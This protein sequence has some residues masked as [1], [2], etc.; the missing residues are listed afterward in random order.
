MRSFS[1]LEF[2]TRVQRA[3]AEM[4][5]ARLD[6]L[7]ITSE[8]NFRYF[9]GFDSQTWISPTRPRYFVL[10]R[11]GVPVAVV[12]ASHLSGMLAT[13]WVSEIRTWQAPDPSDDGMS[14]LASA[15]RE[16]RGSHGAIG[17]EI[18][19]ESRLG[20]PV[21]DFL[22]LQQ[23]L[24]P[25]VIRDGGAVFSVVRMIK[26]PSEIDRIRRAA[27]I[28]SD[29]FETL[30]G[31][32]REGMTERQACSAL[33][34]DLIRRGA[35][36]VPYLVG[37]AGSGG[38]DNTNMG[39]TDRVLARGDILYIDAG[40]TFGGYFCD[41]NR[42]FSFGPPPMEARRAFDAVYRATEA[43]IAAVHP[44]Q[45]AR[46][47]W[48]AMADSL[49]GSGFG[50]ANIG[51]MG[52]GVGLLLTEAPSLNQG[53]HTVLRPGM[54]LTIEPGAAYSA[55]GDETLRL[56]VHEENIV[57]TDTGVELLSGRA[58]AAMPIIH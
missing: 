8:A 2:E 13:S 1:S 9:T 33:H 55:S 15:L 18:G 29:G 19:P 57:V 53:D 42:H 49:S 10:P 30:S 25:T 40:C 56:M 58:P 6:G 17:A 47:L 39:P 37:V 24:Q 5:A 48:Q 36:N 43:G 20:M 14:L 28:L 34:I 38:Y 52:H 11:C 22:R 21:A 41:F 3:C 44:G 45:R 54:V 31:S 27:Q 35:D 26:S 23:M 4:T 51:R 7:L 46:D 16:C 50:G 12:P 32:L